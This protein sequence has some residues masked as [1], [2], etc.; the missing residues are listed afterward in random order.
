MKAT[1]LQSCLPALLAGLCLSSGC[2]AVSRSTEVLARAPVQ[3]PP[4]T[5]CHPVV[6]DTMPPGAVLLGKLEVQVKRLPHKGVPTRAEVLRLAARKA[7]RLGANVLLPTAW[8]HRWSSSR[9]QVAGEFWA[10]A[11]PKPAGLAG[12]PALAALTRVAGLSGMLA[13]VLATCLP[14][15]SRGLLLL[16]GK[17]GRLAEVRAVTGNGTVQ[18]DACLDALR[19]LSSL[20]RALGAFPAGS[21]VPVM[22]LPQEVSR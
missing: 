22:F 20:R 10:I 18:A 15:G 19:T 5:P 11:V 3:R 16:V 6:L 4:E 17:Q 21:V 14:K 9:F 1:S 8:H 13:D 12:G 2:V 7:C